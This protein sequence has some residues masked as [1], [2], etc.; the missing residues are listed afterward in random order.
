MSVHKTAQAFEAFLFYG[1]FIV[2]GRLFYLGK[3]MEHTG[4]LAGVIFGLLI[5]A[6]KAGIGIAYRL[7]TV[8]KAHKKYLLMGSSV[9]YLMLFIGISYLVQIMDVTVYLGKL[10]PMLRTG[11]TIHIIL[12]VL[13]AIWGVYLLGKQNAGHKAVEA[14]SDRGIDIAIHG[15]RGRFLKLRT[16]KSVSTQAW[17]VLAVPCPVCMTVILFSL[18]FLQALFPERTFL[19]TSGLYLVFML[20]VFLTAYGFYCIKDSQNSP[21]TLLAYLMLGVSGYFVLLLVISPQIQGITEVYELVARRHVSTPMVDTPENISFNF[22]NVLGIL[23]L[24]ASVVAGFFWQ[25]NK[26]KKT[27][28]K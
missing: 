3:R 19:I 12:C 28:M 8:D 6:F 17:L 4:I 24:L 23:T 11:T 15:D 25:R 27:I 26:M 13:M 2:H 14:Y 5:F 7:S 1:L 9:A 18:A 22:I 10:L 16:G 20:T 21:E